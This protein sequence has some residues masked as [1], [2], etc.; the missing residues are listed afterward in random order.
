MRYFESKNTKFSFGIRNQGNNLII[1]FEGFSGRT[2]IW[3]GQIVN[4]SIHYWLYS[5]KQLK[6]L[7]PL[8]FLNSTHRISVGIEEKEIIDTLYFKDDPHNTTTPLFWRVT[9]RSADFSI[10]TGTLNPIRS[11]T[12]ELNVEDIIEFLTCLYPKK[13]NIYH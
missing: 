12:R 7:N 6:K 1:L 11:I 4:N 8:T 13:E 5:L 9:R 10:L 3:T 2:F